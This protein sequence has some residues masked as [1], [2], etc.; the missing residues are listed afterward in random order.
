MKNESVSVLEISLHGTRVGH[1]VGYQGGRNV[2]TF[3]T[4][5]RDFFKTRRCTP[6]TS[7]S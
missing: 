6:N 3:D 4:A 7:A 1:L 2:M 5:F